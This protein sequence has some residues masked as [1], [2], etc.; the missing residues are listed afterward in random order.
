MLFW[1]SVKRT[2]RPKLAKKS[3][4]KPSPWDKVMDNGSQNAKP[5]YNTLGKYIYIYI[6]L[7]SNFI[8]Y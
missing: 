4:L 2:R 8:I 1:W 3:G 7:K 6:F 5:I